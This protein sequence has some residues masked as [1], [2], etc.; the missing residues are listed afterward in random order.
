MAKGLTIK[1]AIKVFEERKAIPATEAEKVGI[2][3]LS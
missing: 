2:Y 1:D 3:V